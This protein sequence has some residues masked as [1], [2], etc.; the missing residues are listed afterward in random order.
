MNA[1]RLT[2]NVDF[3]NMITSI[4]L[5]LADNYTFSCYAKADVTNVIVLRSLNFDSSPTT[6][7]ELDGNG[8]IYSTGAIE[9]TIENVGNGWYRCTHV[10]NT[11]SDLIGNVRFQAA[12]S[13][14]YLAKA[15][16]AI[17][18]YG[19][20]LEQGSYATSPITTQGAT[21]TRLKD[22]GTNCGT[23]DDFNSEEGTLFVEMKNLNNPVTSNQHI[24]IS[25]GT[26]SNRFYLYYALDGRV[27]FA[28]FT[29]SILQ[30]NISSSV[31]NQI[32]NLK[33]VA[34]WRLNDFSLWINGVKV[35]SDLS[36]SVPTINTFDRL[37]L[38]D[39]NNLSNLEGEI[40]QLHVYK[41]VLTDAQIQ[42]L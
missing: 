18:I 3:G 42:A 1:S 6:I 25:D 34:V 32:D 40:K 7:F 16:N 11:A 22:A 21:V 24:S 26:L 41:T 37:G 38:N 5:P 39:P 2:T 4:S 12:N 36:G 23:V 8:S 13:I 27:Y 28:G 35:S 19:A 15:G 30:F 10:F 31:L 29:N 9:A 14:N 20:Q 33:I 17:L